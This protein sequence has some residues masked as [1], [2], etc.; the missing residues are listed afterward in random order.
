MGNAV[1]G[2]LRRLKW[3]VRVFKKNPDTMQEL[4][5]AVWEETEVISTETI[6]RVVKNFVRRLYQV[7]NRHHMER[8]QIFETWRSICASFIQ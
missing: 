5:S 7:R 6:T 4:K 8:K 2:K 1:G 3:D